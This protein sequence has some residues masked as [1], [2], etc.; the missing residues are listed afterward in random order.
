[1]IDRTRSKA[2]QT[3]QQGQ[4][5]LSKSAKYFRA[6][7]LQDRSCK[8]AASGLGAVL[9]KGG[10]IDDATTVLNEVRCLSPLRISIYLPAV[11]LKSCACLCYPLR[12]DCHLIISGSGARMLRVDAVYVDQPRASVRGAKPLPQGDQ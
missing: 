1:M 10:A 5:S 2:K 6:C 4:L 7:L 9:A 8:Y 11:T 12:V 3:Q